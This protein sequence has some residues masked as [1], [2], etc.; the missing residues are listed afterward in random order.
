MVLE[1]EYTSLDRK[2]NVGLTDMDFN[3]D[4]PEY[5]YPR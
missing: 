2:L 4:N 3:P 1:E 5:K